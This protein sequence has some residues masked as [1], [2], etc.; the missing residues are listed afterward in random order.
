MMRQYQDRADQKDAWRSVAFHRIVKQPEDFGFKPTN[1]ACLAILAQRHRETQFAREL[2]NAREEFACGYPAD[3]FERGMASS[4][5]DP[6]NGRVVAIAKAL[7]SPDCPMLLEALLLRA[8]DRGA[9][10]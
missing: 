4:P 7:N 2:A 9:I 5:R 6:R 3:W 8:I 1:K 10:S